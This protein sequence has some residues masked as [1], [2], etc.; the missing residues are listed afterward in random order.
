MLSDSLI[1]FVP[2]GTDRI[3]ASYLVDKRMCNVSTYACNTSNTT[4]LQTQTSR[5]QRV[6]VIELMEPSQ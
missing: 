5:M 1:G 2:Q 6:S 3:V 4:C